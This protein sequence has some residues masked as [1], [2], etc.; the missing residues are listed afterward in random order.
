MKTV[1]KYNYFNQ[2]IN[3]IQNKMKITFMDKIDDIE[4]D[5]I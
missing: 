3:N 2:I 5:P 1:K 4:N